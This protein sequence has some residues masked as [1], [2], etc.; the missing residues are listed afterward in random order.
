LI[1]KENR[2]LPNPL[3]SLVTLRGVPKEL[4]WPHIRCQSASAVVK[5]HLRN[6]EMLLVDYEETIGNLIPYGFLAVTKRKNGE[7]IRHNK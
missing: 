4:E 3:D 7:G 5:I 2:L 6:V 1:V